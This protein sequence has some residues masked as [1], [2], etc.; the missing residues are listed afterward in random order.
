MAWKQYIY[1]YIDVSLIT[2]SASCLTVQSTYLCETDFSHGPRFVPSGRSIVSPKGNVP[3]S[4]WS[5][6]P[7]MS[8]V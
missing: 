5:I 4:A 1:M 8:L 3:L 2:V 6:K 7:L